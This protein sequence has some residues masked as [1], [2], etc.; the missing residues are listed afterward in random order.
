MA[1]CYLVQ[2]YW[3]ERCTKT[4]TIRVPEEF[5]ES[6]IKSASRDQLDSLFGDYSDSNGWQTNVTEITEEEWDDGIDLTNE[7]YEGEK[8]APTTEGT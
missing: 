1:R 5:T 8:D 2:E 3:I 7:P 4:V 6:Q